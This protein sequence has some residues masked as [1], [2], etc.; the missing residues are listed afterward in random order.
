MPDDYEVIIQW[1]RDKIAELE[2]ERGINGAKPV[3]MPLLRA[4][5]NV[6]KARKME[7]E[8]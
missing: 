7:G 6:E 8:L 1:F 2:S 3:T 4:L 5:G